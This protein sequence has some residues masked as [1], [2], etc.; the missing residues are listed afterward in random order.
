MS[1]NEKFNLETYLRFVNT[2]KAFDNVKQLQLWIQRVFLQNYFNYNTAYITQKRKIIILDT[3]CKL[4][5]ISVK[6]GKF[7]KV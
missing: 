2:A 6:R 3:N 4:K 5:I 7:I 1:E